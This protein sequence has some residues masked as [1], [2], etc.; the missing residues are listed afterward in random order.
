[1]AGPAPYLQRGRGDGAGGLGQPRKSSN[2][3]SRGRLGPTYLPRVSVPRWSERI[4]RTQ[5]EGQGFYGDSRSGRDAASRFASA[6]RRV[7]MAGNEFGWAHL[8]PSPGSSGLNLIP[9][10]F[11]RDTLMIDCGGDEYSV[12]GDSYLRGRVPLFDTNISASSSASSMGR[13]RKLLGHHTS[14]FL[15]KFS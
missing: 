12:R 13:S 9:R 2:T 7:A 6:A 10:G 14:G 8:L 1:V 3:A 5:D 11:R 15:Y 4:R